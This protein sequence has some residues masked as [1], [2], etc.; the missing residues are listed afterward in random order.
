MKKN[1]L[2]D[3]SLSTLVELLGPV[4]RI[5]PRQLA[6]YA[7]QLLGSLLCALDSKHRSL[8][9]ANIKRAMPAGTEP[10][11][12][13]R[14]TKAFYQKLGQN[15]I[16]I[17]F[18]PLINQDYIQKYVTLEGLSHVHDAFAKGKGVILLTVHAGSWELANAISLNVGLAVVV[19][20]RGQRYPRLSRVLNRYRSLQGGHLMQRDGPVTG[21]AAE[22][23]SIRDIKRC[24][25]N[26]RIIAMTADQGGRQGVLVPFF[27]KEAS[28]A[29][30]AVRLALKYGCALVPVFFTRVHGPYLKVIIGPA[31]Q[32]T[33]TGSI[34]EDT[35]KNVK[36]VTLL[37]EDL[38]RMYPD[39]YLWIYK[40]WKYSKERNI[41]ILSDGKAGHLRQSQAAAN[42]LRDAFLGRGIRSRI[43]IVQVHSKG[44]FL[45]H[46]LSLS[47]LF[48]GKYCCQGCMW[49]LRKTLQESAYKTLATANPDVVISCG[50]QIAGINFLIARENAAKSVVLMRP[51]L[52][53]TRRFDLVIMPRHDKPV[54]RKNVVITDGSLN[55]V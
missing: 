39:E 44:T 54:R 51:G 33:S 23:S 30:G 11:E 27:G 48:A 41:L 43:C 16:D 6:V 1:S 50:S 8:A 22:E 38:I 24:L 10:A 46:C 15:L 42:I 55:L 9:Y 3:Y 34:K 12:I 26:N 45:K 25:Q 37:F 7:G 49:C 18:I 5:L 53:S 21:I 35:W 29:S 47:A 40:I 14:V 36:N 52:L 28:M 13:R 32:L 31:H 17:F 4:L 19:F 20:V 2:I